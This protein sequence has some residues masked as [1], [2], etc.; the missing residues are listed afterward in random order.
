MDTKILAI[1]LPLIF[2]V[3]VILISCFY[4]GDNRFINENRSKIPPPPP[5][6][7]V[8]RVK[9]DID[10]MIEL[11]ALAHRYMKLGIELE[12]FIKRYEDGK[13]KNKLN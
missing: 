1:I 5:P 6:K 11:K 9:L 12:E 3:A 13:K 7:H 10:G 2:I 4:G 8:E